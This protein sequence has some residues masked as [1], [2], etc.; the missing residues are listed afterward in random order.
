MTPP[1]VPV[2]LQPA[3][4]CFGAT[5]T[6]TT[7]T[8]PPT[9]VTYNWYQDDLLI[10]SCGSNQTC[11]FPAQPGSYWVEATNGC[12][13]VR[14]NAVVLPVDTVTVQIQAPCCGT[15]GPVTLSAT[16]TSTLSGTITT[17]GSYV[18]TLNGSVIGS[19]QSITVNPATTT[20]YC[21]KVTSPTGCTAQSC[22]TI[23]VCP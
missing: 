8:P 17:P 20:T 21:V 13:T 10:G 1:A 5:A 4:V 14:S 16:G 2:V 7:T 11:T 19:G 23:T 12:Q 3:P 6:L 22:S 18:W 9:G 15:G